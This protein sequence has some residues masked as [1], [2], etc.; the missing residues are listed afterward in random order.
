MVS[1]TSWPNQDL[2]RNTKRLTKAQRHNLLC[3][4]RNPNQVRTTA[5]PKPAQHVAK[6]LARS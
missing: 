5:W 2:A 3:A 6:I 1:Y 4:F